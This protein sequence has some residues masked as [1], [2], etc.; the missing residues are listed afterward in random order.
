MIGRGVGTGSTWGLRARRG[1]SGAGLLLPRTSDSSRENLSATVWGEW[2]FYDG[3]RG[4]AVA[5]STASADLVAIQN[6][7]LSAEATAAPG[8][9][10]DLGGALSVRLA[11]RGRIVYPGWAFRFRR[12]HSGGTPALDPT[13]RTATQVWSDWYLYDGVRADAEAAATAS[14]DMRVEQEQP[15]SADAMAAAIATGDLSILPRYLVGAA[16]AQASATASMPTPGLGFGCWTRGLWPFA[17]YNGRA[18]SFGYRPYYDDAGALA[19]AA[20]AVTTATG[21]LGLTVIGLAGDAVVRIAVT[22][23]LTTGVIVAEQLS[24]NARVSSTVTGALSTNEISG[25]AAGLVTAAGQVGM[26]S[27]LSAE[28]V[29]RAIAAGTPSVLVPL[30]AS[31]AVVSAVTGALLG[32]TGLGADAEGAASATGIAN[33]LQSLSGSAASMAAA[34]AALTIGA[35][36]AGSAAAVGTVAGALGV[37]VDL[38]ADARARAGA[39]GAT[40]ISVD[41]SGHA[42]GTADATGTLRDVGPVTGGTVYAMNLSNGAVTTLLNFDFERL[43]RA[44][45]A[46]Y[47]LKDGALYKVTGDADPGPTPIPATLRLAPWMPAGVHQHRLDYFYI[48]ARETDGLTVTPIYDE[49]SGVQYQTAANARLGTR[50]TKVNIGLG[51]AWHSLG[52]IVANRNGGQLG[53]AG[54][55]M[56]VSPLSRR[57]K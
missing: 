16:I 20:Q 13:D 30:G 37:G 2:F 8:V 3:L 55:E 46:L 12:T 41:L 36:M 57:P 53:L 44:H 18:I 56:V 31:A 34:V 45:S 7:A 32:A 9:S 35:S 6:V 15:L 28:A 26:A 51:N 19:G 10:G 54:V 47:G 27:P 21:A 17:R 14:A 33:L 48:R 43:T 50:T 39:S 22:G 24:G 52:L 29:A 38:D 4:D 23:D 40:G 25:S 42:T 5:R 49:V 1:L 11:A